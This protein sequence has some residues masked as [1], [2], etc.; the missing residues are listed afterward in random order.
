MSATARVL[1]RTVPG[2]TSGTR[3]SVNR[4]GLPF[5]SSKIALCVAG[6][7]TFVGNMME[8][9]ILE[10]TE[11]QDDYEPRHFRRTLSRPLGMASHQLNKVLVLSSPP[12]SS[13]KNAQTKRGNKSTGARGDIMQL[14]Y[15]RYAVLCLNMAKSPWGQSDLDACS[16]AGY[17]P[18]VKAAGACTPILIPVMSSRITTI[19]HD[20]WECLV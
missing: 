11:P 14:Q 6:I 4:V 3:T 18:S 16:R 13:T 8:V 15:A 19:S 9:T 7:C 5:V 20:Q 10:D 2:R 17:P 1:T 12:A